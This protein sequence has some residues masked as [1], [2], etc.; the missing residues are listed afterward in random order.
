MTKVYSY[1]RNDEQHDSLKIGEPIKVKGKPYRSRV[2]CLLLYPECPEHRKALETIN[3]RGLNY[4][5][6][7]HDSDLREGLRSETEEDDL[8]KF[9]PEFD[10]NEGNGRYKKAHVHV[11]I[12]LTST[13]SNTAFARSIGVSSC[14]VRM[15]NDLKSRLYYLIHL[16]NCN[17]YQYPVDRVCGPLA[18][19]YSDLVKQARLTEKECYDIMREYMNKY[20]TQ[21]MSEIGVCDYLI[22]QGLYWY[23]KISDAQRKITWAVAS[24]NARVDFWS[25]DRTCTKSDMKGEIRF[26]ENSVSDLLQEIAKLEKKLEEMEKK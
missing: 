4:A 23:T 25:D 19:M 13:F 22:S 12:K 26:L 20:P 15:F 8:L 21:R 24:H 1:R 5:M 6:I 16:D 3:E 14:Y 10:E 7:L 9:E 2:A 11:V 18:Y 17:K